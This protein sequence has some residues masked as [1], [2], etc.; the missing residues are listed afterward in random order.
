MAER[1]IQVVKSALTTA[2]N[3]PYIEIEWDDACSPI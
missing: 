1:M 3:D 2:I